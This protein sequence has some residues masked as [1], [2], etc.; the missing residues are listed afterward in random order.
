[1]ARRSDV[2]TLEELLDGRTAPGDAPRSLTRLA[3]LAVT[4]RDTTE[5]EAPT[6]EFRARLRAELLEVAAAG[7]PTFRDRVADRVDQA[8]ARVR[9]SLR[10]AGAAAVASTMIGTAGV[11]AA[12]QSALPGDV[13]YSVKDLTEDARLAFATGDVERGRL[14]LAFARER[15]E[16]VEAGRDRLAPRQLTETLDRLDRQAA[17][18]AEELLQAA[19]AGD[20]LEVLTELDAFTAEV[21]GR[22][23]ELTPQLPL[24]VRPAAERTL[25]VLRRIDLQVAGLLGLGGESCSCLGGA[26]VQPRVVLPGDG[27]AAPTCRCVPGAGE[28][29][30]TTEP[31]EQP[32]SGPTDPL[33]P[34]PTVDADPGTVGSGSGEGGSVGDLGSAVDDTVGD[35]G[36]AVDDTV[37]DLGTTVDDLGTLVDDVLDPSATTTDGGLVGDTTSTLEGTVDGVGDVVEDTSSELGSSIGGL[38]D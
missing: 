25:E 2:E 37:D 20:E 14:H 21:R 9:H 3:D 28:G 18:G 33:A 32:Q 29:D 12:A 11:A 35:L 15:L 34:A 19:S 30:G 36:S 1:M 6:D 22:L 38:L 26:G 31:V 10:A 27:P 8:T 16:E 5:L 17:A 4:V 13:L 24:S 7:R 23:L